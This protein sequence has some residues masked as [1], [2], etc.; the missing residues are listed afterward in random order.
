[1][2][3]MTDDP[4]LERIVQDVRAGEEHAFT[5]LVE[6][7]R[8][9]VRRWASRLTGDADVA[10]DIAQDVMI[11]LER[12]VQQ[13]HGDSRF[14]TWLFSVTRNAAMARGRTQVRRALLNVKHSTDVHALPRDA[15][16]LLDQ[17]RVAD[18]VLRHF[19][20]LPT[21]QKQVFERVDLRGASVQDVALELGI[22]AA[23]VRVHLFRA[24][25][26]IRARMLEFHEP[27]VKEY[28][29]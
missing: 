15:D 16:G 27:L 25:R 12:R 3:L 7:V 13:Y 8:D 20:A 21:R 2:T 11:S 9:R 26:S 22:P 24:R 19:D 1:M 5:A 17:Q 14:T 18:L 28:F 10:E 4:E 6:R 29:E 23:T